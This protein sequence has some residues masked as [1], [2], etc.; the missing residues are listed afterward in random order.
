[1]KKP[2][3]ASA[4][5]IASNNE[6]NQAPA[7]TSIFCDYRP[8]E[9][10]F[11]E[12]VNTEGAI[13]PAWHDLIRRLDAMG[14]DELATRRQQASKQI[15]RDGIT[16]NPH[17]SEGSGSRPWML[18]AIPLILAEAEWNVLA[19]KLSQRARLMEALLKDLFGE[20][21]L[22]RER[23]LPPELLFGHPAWHPAYQ[24]LAPANQRI[25]EY[26]VADL[27]RAPNGA[28]WVTGDRTKSPFGLGYVLENRIVTSRML[29][30]IFRKLPIRKLAPFYATLK[31]ELRK[32]APRSKENPRIILWTRGPAS[33]S[34]FEDSYLARYLGYT[35]AE[36]G[37]LAL[38]GGTI[39]LKTL[40]GLLPV[41]V[42]FRRLD[43]EDGDPIELNSSSEFGIPGL[44]DVIRNHKVAVSNTI[45]SRLVESPVFLPYLPEI[46]RTLLSEEIQLPSVFTWW[47][48]RPEDREYVLNHLDELIIRPAFRMQNEAPYSTRDLSRA[49]RDELIAKINSN[50]NHYVAQESVLRSTT[51]VVVDGTI[52]PWHLAL[53]T[54]LVATSDNYRVLPGAL[55]RV[56]PESTTL[57]FTMTFGERSQD[58][59]ILTNKHVDEISLLDSNTKQVLP[60]RSGSELPSRAADNLYWL[61]R[62][63]ERAEQ[64]ARLYRTVIE[65]LE[66]ELSDELQHGP[67]LR[68]LAEQGHIDPDHII[69]ELNRATPSVVDVLPK[70]IFDLQRPF[71]LRTTVNNVVY[72]AHRVRDRI[73]PDMWRTIDRIQTTLDPSRYDQNLRGFDAIL[74]LD[75]LL[76]DFAGFAGLVAESMTRTLG[77]RFLDLGV[78]IERSSQTNTLLRS[79]LG[80]EPNDDPSIIEAVLRVTN[81]LMTYRNRYLATYQVPVLLDLLLTDSTNPRSILFQ[82]AQI[83]EHL[84]AMPR[85]EFQAILTPEQKLGL[86]IANTV[87]L[88]DIYELSTLNR[89]HERPNLLKLCSQLD[90]QLPLLS[91]A[92]SGRYLIHAG[93][94]RHL[95]TVDKH[96]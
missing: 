85:D 60:R 45:G 20:Q 69:P 32:L 19:A 13:R 71:G 56:A 5:K 38:R 6:L 51:P 50:P 15:A 37:D 65:T 18:G 53:R 52:R 80:T 63:I 2:A 9:G 57:N 74:L 92:V 76:A 14:L 94:P 4:G 83:N 12:A 49:H 8:I 90:E 26:Y 86:S 87:R 35:L 17:D 58:V 93:L 47:C 16:F 25:L 79:F 75:Q 28:W 68:Y 36:G 95:G 39:H 61:G 3:N 41:E 59:W 24:G 22:I 1:M 67:M 89:D 44:L 55:A 11:D 64:T 7:S 27:A 54:F 91:D 70:S 21:R 48:G 84:N 29:S 78:R 23:I 66:S 34:Y 73:A 43:D 82:M 72:N 42:L 81:S 88:A 96:A 30:T 31:E 77:C 40:G 10:V 33:R 46:C 62:N